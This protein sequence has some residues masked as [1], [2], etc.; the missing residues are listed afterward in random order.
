MFLRSGDESIVVSAAGY[1]RSEVESRYDLE[2]SD[3]SKKGRTHG[4]TDNLDM[5]RALLI[6]LDVGSGVRSTQKE[7]ER[8]RGRGLL[9][10]GPSQ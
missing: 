8:R 6:L 1:A 5:L 7:P 4:F 9:Y 2:V 3:G 10:I